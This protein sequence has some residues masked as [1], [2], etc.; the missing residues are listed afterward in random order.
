MIT[1]TTI[2]NR[3]AHDILHRHCNEPPLPQPERVQRGQILEQWRATAAF[4]SSNDDDNFDAS[5][6]FD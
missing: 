6:L 1:T 3:Y 2:N 5:L 4:E